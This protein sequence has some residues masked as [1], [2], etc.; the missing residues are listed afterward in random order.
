M[1]AIITPRSLGGD[2]AAIPSKSHLHRLLICA[3]LG[4]LPPEN[5]YPVSVM[6]EDIRA[7]VGCLASL[8]SDI[9]P[10]A[11]ALW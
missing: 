5:P 7:T 8:G 4:D 10:R 2:I 6:P 9:K 3:A 1:D 11:T